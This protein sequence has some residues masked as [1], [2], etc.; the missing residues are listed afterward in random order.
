[1]PPDLCRAVTPADVKLAIFQINDDKAP[2]PDGY[3]LCFFKK[4]WNIVGDLVCRAVMDFFRSGGMLRQLNHTITPL[5]PNSSTLPQLLIIDRFRVAIKWSD[6][7]RGSGFHLVVPSTS[8][9]VRLLTR[10][11]GRFSP[12]SSTGMASPHFLSLGLSNDPFL[13]SDIEWLP[14][15][16]F[17]W[18]ERSTARRPDVTDSLPSLHG[19]LFMTDQE[20]YNKLRLQLPPEM[21]EAS[22][23]NDVLDEILARTEF[24]RSE[25]PVRYLG[26]P[27]A[28]KR[29]SATDF[30]P[31]VD[32]I[33]SCI[34]KWTAKSLSFTGWLKLIRL[35]IQSVECFWLQVFPLPATV[36]EKI[37]RLYRALL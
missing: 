36:I 13:F 5:C 3:T 1:M 11:H 26:I 6:S 28:A 18:E 2:G 16:I 27:L 35:V 32:Q 8:T 25:M 10:S 9:Y 23:E 4:A 33:A 20:E 37:H 21:L 7:T 31:F 15:W 30:S 17:P 14:T 34:R 12:E 22:I 19:V 24:A 29:L